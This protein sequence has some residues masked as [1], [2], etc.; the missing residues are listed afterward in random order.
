M[1]LATIGCFGAEWDMER[2]AYRTCPLCEATCGLELRIE[3]E[4]VTRIRGDRDDVFSK[5]FLCPKG[6]ALGA[7][8]EDPDRLR[9]PM[10]KRDGVHE[11]AS[12]EEAYAEIQQRLLPA[13]DATER[14]GGA[15]YLG[16]PVVHSLDLLLYSKAVSLAVGSRKVFS[17]STVDQRPREVAS[18]LVYGSSLTIPVPDVDRTDCLVIV[19]ANPVV[20]NGS[21]ATAPDWPG[22][23]KA[24]G[25]RGG[26]VIVIDPARTKTAEL[27][28]M[29]LA[30]IPGTDPLLIAALATEIVATGR[31]RPVDEDRDRLL[32]V[33]EQLS[34]FTAESVAGR[35]GVTPDEIR[36]LAATMSDAQRPCLYGRLGTTITPFGT[37]T[38][39]L[40]D[41]VN[42]LLGALDAPGG[43]MFPANPSGSKNTRGDGPSGPV[44]SLGRRTTSSGLPIELGEHPVAA[45]AEEIESGDISALITVAGNPVLSCPDSD[46]LD[47]ALATLDYMVS[48]DAYLNETTRH[49]DV[50]LPPP[51]HLQKSHFD[52]AFANLSVRNIANY[53][54]AVFPL[55]EGQLPEWEVVARLASVLGGGGADHDAA[56]FVDQLLFDQLTRSAAASNSAPEGLEQEAVAAALSDH[57]PGPERLL[58]VLLQS[59]P[60]GAWFGED[61][62][63]LSLQQLIDQPHGIDLGAL[64]P[65]L[66]EVLLT[67]SERPEFDHPDLVG[68]LGRLEAFLQLDTNGALTL[69]N[70]RTLR[71]NNSWMHNL[72]ILVKGKPRCT[73]LIHPE[74]A[75]SRHLADGTV[76]TVSS[77]AGSVDISVELDDTIRPGVV[78]IPHGWG[79]A[80]SGTAQSVAREH[81]GVNVNV[82]TPTDHVD[83]LSGTSQLTGFPVEVCK[84]G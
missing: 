51:S 19:G 41:I 1:L 28:D 68:D 71:S 54:E 48:V 50:I 37:T 36:S 83:P 79:H 42:A 81:A 70:R 78:S 58:D 63:G 20:S 18:A 30:P 47:A 25:E 26:S 31:H 61:P 35:V 69:I 75:A 12:W 84:A 77:T 66:P 6:T 39:W 74:D 44:Q 15:V 53:S 38:S 57:E 13:L 16:N 65:R 64:E 3:D 73:L 7:F 4:R 67:P 43:A 52:L 14:Q 32:A 46:R 33:V 23:L 49:A 55:D 9:S 2:T 82:L 62:D 56:L 45:L 27:A 29:H 80:K 17:A 21:L 40:I 5:G 59:G 34:A 76:A 60:F 72:R 11:P 10:I 24:V 8:H 22:R